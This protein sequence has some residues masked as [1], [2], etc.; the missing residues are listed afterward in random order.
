MDIREIDE[1]F[2]GAHSVLFSFRTKNATVPKI[3]PT[4]SAKA[5]GD[6]KSSQH[7]RDGYPRNYP[8]DL[9]GFQ[10]LTVH[11]DSIP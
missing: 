11:A 5:G 4:T 2:Y 3:M 7:D 10:A 8:F 6:A 1:N 9:R